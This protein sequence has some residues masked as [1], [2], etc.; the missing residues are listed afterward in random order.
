[1]ICRCC[2][3]WCCWIKSRDAI[4]KATEELTTGFKGLE[5]GQR[6]EI[7]WLLADLQRQGEP[8]QAA[9]ELHG[10]LAEED[11]NDSRPLLALALLRRNKGIRKLFT[12][13]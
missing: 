12:P 3:C 10:E 7:G 6:L 5:P 8:P 11:A 4:T 13:C 9:I 1:M 2:S